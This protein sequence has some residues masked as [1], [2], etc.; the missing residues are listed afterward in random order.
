M[1]NNFEKNL[2]SYL[3]LFGGLILGFFF[4]LFFSYNRQLQLILGIIMSIYY[5]I[6]GI[7]HHWFKKDLTIKVFVEYFLISL[8][9]VVIL[10]TLLLRT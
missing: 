8:I 1:R 9:G 10:S 2:T 4:F 6:W 5:L 7:I 3:I